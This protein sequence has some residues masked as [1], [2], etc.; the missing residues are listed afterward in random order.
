MKMKIFT[1]TPQAD[2]DTV[3]LASYFDTIH[4]VGAVISAGADA[5]LCFV[6]PTY[7]GTDV[8]LAQKEEDFTAATDWTSAE[9]TLWVIGTDEGI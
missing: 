4:A 8:T 5:N 6:V 2:G 9:I 3:A 7:S 1:M